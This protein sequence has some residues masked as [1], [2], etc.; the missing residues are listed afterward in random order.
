[1]KLRNKL[2]E[3][4][5]KARLI[6]DAGD[7]NAWEEPVIVPPSRRPRPEQYGSTTHLQ[8]AAK[9]YVLSVLHRL[10]AEANLTFAQPDNVDIAV[11]RRSGEAC[12]IDVKTLAGTNR[13][14]VEPFEA[15]KDHFLVFILFKREWHYPQVVPDIYIWTSESLRDFITHY[16][17]TTV[18]LEAVASKLDPMS[19]W[20]DFLK[21]PA[22]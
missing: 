5:I 12:T 4:Q 1:M 19:A 10:G 8:L 13:W 14:P 11:V 6:E 20:L 2:L 3:K 7:P 9:F 17:R 21:R 15:R 18:S 16:K 22:A